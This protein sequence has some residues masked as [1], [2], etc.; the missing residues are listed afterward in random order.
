MV[1]SNARPHVI[2]LHFIR[3][4]GIDLRDQYGFLTISI[5]TASGIHAGIVAPV[6]SLSCWAYF[7]NANRRSGQASRAELGDQKPHDAETHCQADNV[8]WR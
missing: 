1:A 8:C 7:V 2:H 3:T 4:I 5:N 6:R